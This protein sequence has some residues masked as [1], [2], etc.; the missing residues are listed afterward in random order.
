MALLDK[1]QLRPFAAAAF[2]PSLQ[3]LVLE[4]EK[5]RQHPH[6]PA[7]PSSVLAH[8]YLRGDAAARTAAT[9]FG[10]GHAAGEAEVAG[11]VAPGVLAGGGA[12]AYADRLGLARAPGGGVGARR[13]DRWRR[14]SAV[15]VAAVDAERSGGAA[16]EG[17]KRPR[18]TPDAGE[19]PNGPGGDGSGN[20]RGGWGGGVDSSGGA[21]AGGDAGVAPPP[22]ANDAVTD[23]V[24]AVV[25]DACGG[26]A[27][28]ASTGGAWLGPPGR[29]GAAAI[30][31]AAAG[32]DP[33]G[34]AAAAASGVSERLIAGGVAAT[35]ARALGGG[36]P[37]AAAA[38]AGAAS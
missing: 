32:V 9:P 29:L 24:G 11:L 17:R 2:A 19:T 34:V 13:E 37:L 27:A 21:A 33:A 26:V 18:P 8:G 15:V 6:E 23:T 3:V 4:V 1:P 16:G 20:G 31:G 36:C 10:A 12:A 28:A 25:V 35:L 22:P 30:P 7:S 14:Y 38:A 5:K